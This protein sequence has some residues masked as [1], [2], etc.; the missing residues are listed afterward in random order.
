M[1]DTRPRGRPRGS[2]KND[3]PFLAQVADLLVRDP[4]T[5]PTTAMK[6]VIGKRKDWQ[7]SDATLLRRWQVKWPQQKESLLT[8]ARERARPRP[9]TI[10]EVIEG[11]A[12]FRR[13]MEQVL[14]NPN[15]I[16]MMEGM[17]AISRQLEAAKIPFIQNLQTFANSP[18]AKRLAQW[19]ATSPL[20]NG[21]PEARRWLELSRNVQKVTIPR[22]FIPPRG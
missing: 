12:A 3:T 5:K 15:L 4:S 9:P 13:G 8:A 14:S 22:P 6:R 20:A 18:E 21:S 2:G 16:R 11:M 1:T 17:T 7:S 10:Q 19:W